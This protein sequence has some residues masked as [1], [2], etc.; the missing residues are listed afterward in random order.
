MKTV[1]KLVSYLHEFYWNYSQFLAIY[2]M[3]FS[4]EVIFNSENTDV[5]VPPVSRRCP[6]RAHLSATVL[7][8]AVPR[9]AAVGGGVRMHWAA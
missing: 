5:W 3:L 1:P 7:R 4:I 2:Y 6:C 8:R 9:L